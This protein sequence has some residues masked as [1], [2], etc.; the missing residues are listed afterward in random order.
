MDSALH[1]TGGS[2]TP[3]LAWR[4]PVTDLLLLGMALIW[5][6]NYIVVKFGTRLFVPVVFST[7]RIAV[8][9]VVLWTVLLVRRAP[10][11]A[12]RDVAPL[13]AL[14]LLGNGL[15]QLFFVEGL[16]RTRASD[17]A[18]LCAASPIFI[19]TIGWMR[20]LET[21]D[22]RGRFGILLSVIGIAFVVS[23]G[24]HGAGDSSMLGNTL[25][26]CASL[27]WSLYSVLLKPYTERID[28]LTISAVTMSGGLVPMLM[29]SSSALLA[30]SWNAVGLRGWAALAYSGV[31]ALVI[32][33]LCWYR[34]VRV[35]GPTRAAMYGNLQPV[36]AMTAAWLLLGE[37]PRSTQLLGGAL[38]MSGLL[39]TRLRTLVPPATGE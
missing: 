4:L 10:L 18:L 25:V 8:A 7:T 31:V 33:Y 12:R 11:P 27:C 9:V 23:G 36:F 14:G 26:L 3:T 37:S 21:I 13:L 19:E 35:L 28:G 2:R 24:T 20:G 15:Y 6:L 32:G 22:A 38:I 1:V 16:A 29:I 17:A 5:G 39:L 34:G 30:T